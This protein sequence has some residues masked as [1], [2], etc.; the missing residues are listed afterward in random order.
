MLLKSF[1]PELFRQILLESEALQQKLLSPTVLR[2]ELL[3]R[4]GR[5][6]VYV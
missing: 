2:L 4:R 5:E 6:D 3:E 1:S